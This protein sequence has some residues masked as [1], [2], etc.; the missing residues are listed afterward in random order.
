M[1]MEKPLVTVAR[2]RV[3]QKIGASRLV[4]D[5]TWYP[6]KAA[7]QERVRFVFDECAMAS[8]SCGVVMSSVI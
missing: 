8:I 3:D 5:W 2:S 6:A 4:A 7:G 1:L